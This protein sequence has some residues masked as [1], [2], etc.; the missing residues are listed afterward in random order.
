MLLAIKDRIRPIK[1]M[2]QPMFLSSTEKEQRKEAEFLN[3]IF[4]NLYTNSETRKR[5]EYI[6]TINEENSRLQE[7]LAEDERALPGN[8][9]FL[10]SGWYK[11]MLTRYAFA[12]HYVKGKK[13]LDTC[14]GL[15]W[16]AYLLEVVAGSLIGIELDQKAIQA[17]KEIW[18]YD[19]CVL[20]Q[21]SVLNLPFPDNSFDVVTAMESIE[22]FTLEDAKIY[23]QEMHRVL[24]PGGRLIGS[25]PLPLTEEGIQLELNT[26]PYH[27]HVFT[28]TKLGAFLRGYFSKVH[29]LHNNRYFWAIK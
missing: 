26:N 28:P 7:V 4:E 27:L 11:S 9:T 5:V 15:G 8:Q 10:E 23:T 2:I 20:Q 3:N 1:S 12:M 14:S 16:G 21:G 22:H 24:K 13:V 25:T 6:L 17:A 29:V 18:D 19:K